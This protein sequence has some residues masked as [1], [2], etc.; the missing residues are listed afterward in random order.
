MNIV[1]RLKHFEIQI[2]PDLLSVSLSNCP[3]I[4]ICQADFKQRGWANS[5]IRLFSLNCSQRAHAVY[6]SFY[7]SVAIS[8]CLYFHPFTGLANTFS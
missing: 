3:T 6:L 4:K 5:S 7:S 2:C 1:K 8:L